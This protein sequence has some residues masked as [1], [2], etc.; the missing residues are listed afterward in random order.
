MSS[1][2]DVKV[3]DARL[4]I[5]LLRAQ[6]KNKKHI[7]F[8]YTLTRIV[9]FKWCHTYGVLVKCLAFSTNISPR[10]GFLTG[11]VIRG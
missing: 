8:T 2:V 4:K 3:L 7:L 6:C 9:S 5:A 1:K 11:S 10:W